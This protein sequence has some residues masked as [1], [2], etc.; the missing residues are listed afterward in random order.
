MGGLDLSKEE[1]SALSCATKQASN[2]GMDLTLRPDNIK[3]LA[4]QQLR[5]RVVD[6]QS[7]ILRLITERAPR[8]GSPAGL[9]GHDAASVGCLSQDELGWHLKHLARS[10]LASYSGDLNVNAHVE[11]TAEG[12]KLAQPLP[13]PGGIPGQCFV[14]MWFDESMAEAFDQGI[15]PA[16]KDC[17]YKAVRIDRKEHNNQITDEIMAGIR[18]S[19]FMIADFTGQR[20]GVYYEAGFARGLGRPVISCCREGEIGNLHFD[21]KI[22]SHVTWM[23]AANLREKLA[24][25]IKATIVPKG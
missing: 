9:S 14:A 12:W 18:D 16:V 17:G 22:I 19:Q 7:Q 25:R 5:T 1:K 13:R 23:D 11:L 2:S 6:V 21:T 4:A 24:R 20:A 15:E 10:G 8:P 3:E